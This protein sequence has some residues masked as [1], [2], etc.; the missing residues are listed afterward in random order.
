M[1]GIHMPQRVVHIGGDGTFG[2]IEIAGDAAIGKFL[3]RVQCD[4]VK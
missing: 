1:L 3:C 4:Q 2:S